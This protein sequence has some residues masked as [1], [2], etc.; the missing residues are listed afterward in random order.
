MG[1]AALAIPAASSSPAVFDRAA[2]DELVVAHAYLCRRGARKFLRAGLERLDLEQVAAIGLIKAS[3]TFRPESGTPFEAYAWIVI[4]GE[5]MHYV[6][7]HERAIRIPRSLLRLESRYRRAHEACLVR[8]EREPSDAEIAETMGVLLPVA[9]ELRLARAT[10]LPAAIDEAAELP[11]RRTDG[12]E[13]EDRLLFVE[14]FARLE[15]LERTLLVG[16]YVRGMSRLE[17]ARRLGLSPRRVARSLN[18]ALARM[19]AAWA[20]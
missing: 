5:L 7:D 19:R 6:R 10:A 12:L 16:V 8:L 9:I 15:R 2:A 14:A 13:T 17:L 3:R 11:A 20:L 4:L 18:A 1:H